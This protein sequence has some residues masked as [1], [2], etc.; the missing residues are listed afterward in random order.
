MV[1]EDEVDLGK[2]L[3]WLM[4]EMCFGCLYCAL[5][6]TELNMMQVLKRNIFSCPMLLFHSSASQKGHKRKKMNIVFKRNERNMESAWY[7]KSIYVHPLRI[8]CYA[9]FG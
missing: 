4:M 2:L 1:S 6:Q 9:P 8:F 5:S 7:T 3:F